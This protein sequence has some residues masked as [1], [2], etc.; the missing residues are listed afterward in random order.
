MDRGAARRRPSVCA[1]SATEVEIFLYVHSAVDGDDSGDDMVRD[2]AL[3]YL[4]VA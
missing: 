2:H 3:R 4:G 1:R